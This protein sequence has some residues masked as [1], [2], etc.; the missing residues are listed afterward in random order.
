M[1]LAVRKNA[2]S[3]SS[4][5]D[6]LLSRVA[7]LPTL[8][9]IPMRVGELLSDPNSTSAQIAELLRRDQVL[10]A[11]IL[12]LVNSGYYA[13]PGGVAS[14]ER[15]LAFLGFSTVA[16]LVLGISVFS[17]FKALATPRLT[18]GDFW[19]HALSVAV[20]SEVIAR[21]CEGVKPE[22]AFTAGLLHDIGKLVLHEVEPDR[23]REVVELAAKQKETF[24]AAEKEIGLPAHTVLGEAIAT[25]WGLPH[26]LRLAIRYHHEDLAGVETITRPVRQLVACV[27][28]A[29]LL[30]IKNAWGK[31]GDASKGKITHSELT[32]LDMT[33]D[34]IEGLEADINEAI[35]KAGGLFSV[36]S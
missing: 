28:L 31:S 15:A 7:E 20:A 30:A 10:A 32:P 14:V 33:N 23:L 19:K 2:P 3:K 29:N 4:T 6:D 5:V 16:Q 12:R 9:A 22:D 36:Y 35:G 34:A 11:K 8:P 18:M 26:G 17:Q 21:R 24:F 27:R 1:G 25:R 13:I